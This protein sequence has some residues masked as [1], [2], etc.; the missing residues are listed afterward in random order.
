MLC[1]ILAVLSAAASY[2]K[3]QRVIHA[4]R[5]WLNA[6]GG[7]RWK[8][9]PAPPAL[10]YTRHGLSLKAVERAFRLQAAQLA[11]D[12]PAAQQIALAGKT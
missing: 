2:R 5:E 6:L 10:R 3:P 1:S 11:R 12:R 7:L 4:P 9:A 8:R